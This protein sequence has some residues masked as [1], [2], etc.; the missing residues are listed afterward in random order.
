MHL[1]YPHFNFINY[2]T[3]LEQSFTL[4]KTSLCVIK[5]ELKTII[6]AI[7][8]HF[9]RVISKNGCVYMVSNSLKLMHKDVFASQVSTNLVELKC[10]RYS[11]RKDVAVLF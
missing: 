10:W 7:F 6:K 1:T 8:A 3:K 2:R 11:Q 4:A 5:R 9:C